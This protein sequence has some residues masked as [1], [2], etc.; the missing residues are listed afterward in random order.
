[1]TDAVNKDGGGSTSL[2][3]FD[4]DGRVPWM[5]NHHAKGAVRKNAVNLGVVFGQ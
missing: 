2:V 4:R 5:L 3:V 1:M